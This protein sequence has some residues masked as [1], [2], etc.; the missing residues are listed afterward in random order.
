MA[1]SVN[2]NENARL[3]AEGK[4]RATRIETFAGIGFVL[5]S[6]IGFF[7]FIL[8]PVVMSLGISFCNW[9][10][11]K[12]WGA[13]EFTGLSNFIKM[14]SDNWFFVS[15]KNNILFTAI[16]I[17]VLIMLGL[18]MGEIINRHVFGGKIIEYSHAS[19]PLVSTLA[20]PNLKLSTT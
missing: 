2:D 1:K 9:N 11:L 7:V 17:P 6:F 18:I 5:P 15:F 12:G 19:A 14:F 20:P 8:V 3:I 10:F 13:I 4:K 16:T